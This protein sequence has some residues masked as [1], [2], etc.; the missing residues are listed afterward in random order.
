MQMDIK[1]ERMAREE[2]IADACMSAEEQIANKQLEQGERIARMQ[3]DT[4]QVQAKT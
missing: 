3:A 2:R 4:A 1:R